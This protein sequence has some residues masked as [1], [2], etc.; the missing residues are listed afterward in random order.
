MAL[1]RVA[2]PE[3]KHVGLNQTLNRLCRPIFGSGYPIMLGAQP[4]YFN[5]MA[6]KQSKTWAGSR[7]RTARPEKRAFSGTSR[8][9]GFDSPVVPVTDRILEVP[10]AVSEA[11]HRTPE[12]N[13]YTVHEAAVVE[14]SCFGLGVLSYCRQHRPELVESI[15]VHMCSR[16][17]VEF[18]VKHR[19]PAI[20]LVGGRDIDCYNYHRKLGFERQPGILFSKE[21]NFAVSFEGVKAARL[22]VES[23]ESPKENAPV[24][25][26][27][28]SAVTSRDEVRKGKARAVSP[29]S[30]TPGKESNGSAPGPGKGASPPVGGQKKENLKPLAAGAAP[31]KPQATGRRENSTTPSPGSGT[32]IQLGKGKENPKPPSQGK[33]ASEPK[34]SGK[35]K[36]NSKPAGPA[37]DAPS[38]KKAKGR[39]RKDSKPPSEGHTD[40]ATLGGQQEQAT[41]SAADMAKAASAGGDGKPRKNKP[42]G[43]P[44]GPAH[45]PPQDRPV[46]RNKRVP[47]QVEFQEARD[48]A[49]IAE[50]EEAVFDQ[51]KTLFAIQLPISLHQ[52]MCFQLHEAQ[53]REQIIAEEAASRPKIPALNLKPAR[54]YG[55]LIPPVESKLA[56]AL[57]REETGT[58]FS[59]KVSAPPEFWRA[60]QAVF[61][62]GPDVNLFELR[63]EILLRRRI[64]Q[65]DLFYQ[66]LGAPC[67]TRELLTNGCFNPATFKGF[68]SCGKTYLLRVHSICVAHDNLY[69][70]WRVKS[71]IPPFGVKVTAP[72]YTAVPQD[73]PRLRELA[74]PSENAKYRIFYAAVMAHA[75]KEV[76]AYLALAKMEEFASDVRTG[77]EPAEVLQSVL[78]LERKLSAIWP[79][80]AFEA[81]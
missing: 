23:G 18:I 32:P 49:C 67:A 13:T 39:R 19:L 27:V 7:N 80:P 42:K 21:R 66:R 22:F 48:R 43:P 41:S 26:D 1:R 65:K 24:S 15:P 51:L 34:G 64:F 12:P 29:V 71:T 25:K 74:A 58:E 77:T 79:A 10:K 11:I 62:F 54:G 69:C 70:I 73:P 53:W 55:H 3:T 45:P 76:Q 35:E 38:A 36:G 28:N 9:R 46:P 8:A 56:W 60:I 72:A 4:A 33:G 5:A 68:D 30:S 44:P 61:N 50:E 20:E 2:A 47:T 52:S 6:P 14:K 31:S 37:K 57:A 59:K 81:A 63:P 17:L 16:K 78:Q 40:P 75:P